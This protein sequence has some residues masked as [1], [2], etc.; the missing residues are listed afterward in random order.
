MQEYVEFVLCYVQPHISLLQV[1]AYV[2][3]SQLD[4]C[5]LQQVF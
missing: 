3:S 2:T 5:C 1:T 4:G